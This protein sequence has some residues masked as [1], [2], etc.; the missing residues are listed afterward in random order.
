MEPAPE[1]VQRLLELSQQA[2]DAAD[3]LGHR[4]PLA[5]QPLELAL[6]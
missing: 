5:A 2:H 6:E 4:H 1:L 3:G